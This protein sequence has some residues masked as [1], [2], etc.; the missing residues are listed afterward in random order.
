M[1]DVMWGL[2]LAAA[3]EAVTIFCR[4]G[5][6]L[7]ATRDTGWIAP[8]TFGWRIH[9]GYCGVLLLALA[10][11]LGAAPG[12]RSAAIIVGIGLAVSDFVHHFLVLW[13]LTGS[14]ELDLRYPDRCNG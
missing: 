9:H 11:F 3:I 6:G 14:P 13:P 12:L 10:L 1:T 4:F 5:L 8:Y 7:K 2:A